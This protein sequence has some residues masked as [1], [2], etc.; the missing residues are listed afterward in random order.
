[1]GSQ[2]STSYLASALF[3][4]LGILREL[5]RPGDPLAFFDEDDLI[6]LHIL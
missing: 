6:H 2:P 1:M 3:A 5:H 4:D